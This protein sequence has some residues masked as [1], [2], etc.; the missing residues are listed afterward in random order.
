MFSSIPPSV[1]P[2]YTHVPSFLPFHLA[3]S[4]PLCCLTAAVGKGGI[5][6]RAR[7]GHAGREARHHVRYKGGDPQDGVHGRRAHL[8]G[9]HQGLPCASRGGAQDAVPLLRLETLSSGLLSYGYWS[10]Q[11]MF[12]LVVTCRWWVAPEGTSDFFLCNFCCRQE[13]E[14]DLFFRRRNKRARHV[15]FVKKGKRNVFACGILRMCI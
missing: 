11:A 12:L 15:P 13:R 5:R 4:F 8:G 7:L 3:L 9:G 2:S 1:R 10:L 6:Q 14:E